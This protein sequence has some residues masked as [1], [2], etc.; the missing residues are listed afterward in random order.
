[1][2]KEKGQIKFI[3][4]DDGYRIEV[5]GKDLKEMFSCCCVPMM[6]AAKAI[7]VECREPGEEKK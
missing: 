1:M 5:K 7:K 4:T 2:E 6:G 3:E